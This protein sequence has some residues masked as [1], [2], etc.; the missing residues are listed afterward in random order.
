M[1]GSMQASSESSGV[2]NVAA[3]YYI[4]VILVHEDELVHRPY[5]RV[6]LETQENKDSHWYHS[7]WY[8][9]GKLGT[10]VGPWLLLSRRCTKR[11]V[12][13]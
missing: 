7:C 5:T 1:L 9:V 8:K 4:A 2:D 3:S 13:S 11:W 6:R 12:N 10:V